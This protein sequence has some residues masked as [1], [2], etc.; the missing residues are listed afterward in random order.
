[1][2]D[3][4]VIDY[5]PDYDNNL[6]VFAKTNDLVRSMGADDVYKPV[7]LIA[8][9]TSGLMTVDRE[10]SAMAFTTSSNVQNNEY[11]FNVTI[12]DAD[13]GSDIY[14]YANSKKGGNVT[15]KGL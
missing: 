11:S 10:S 9:E 5:A 7:T 4:A 6:N 2:T 15:I 12:K 8:G 13:I 1:M 3:P 14:M